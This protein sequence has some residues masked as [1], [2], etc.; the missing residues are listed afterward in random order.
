M[1]KNGCALEMLYSGGNVGLEVKRPQQR[2]STMRYYS[3]ASQKPN[4]VRK[5]RRRA[6]G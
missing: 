3:L 4:I 2:H 1:A 6:Y 5:R